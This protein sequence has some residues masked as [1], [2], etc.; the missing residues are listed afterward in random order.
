MSVPSHESFEDDYDRR[1]IVDFWDRYSEQFSRYTRGTLEDNEWVGRKLSYLL[2]EVKNLRIADLGTGA[3]FVAISFAQLGHS[4]IATDI[5]ERMIEEA[6]KNAE[7]YDVDIDFRL[8][9]IEHTKLEKGYFDLVILRDVIFNIRDIRRVSSEVVDLIRPGGYLVVADGNYFLHCHDEDYMHRHDYH[10]IRD[11]MGEYQKMTEMS[12]SQYKELEDLVKTFEVNTVCRP[13]GD[14]YLLT[15]LGLKNTTISCDDADDYKKLTEDGWTQV[16]FRYTLVAQK[17][18]DHD[19]FTSRTSYYVDDLFKEKKTTAQ[20]LS[21]IFEALSNPDRVRILNVLNNGPA[22]V[23]TIS[24]AVKLSEKMT[25]YHLTL[26]KDLGIVK[27]EKV[28]RESIYS[29]TDM[30]AVLN[31]FK[32][33]FEISSHH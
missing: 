21:K 9:D 19:Q 28:G 25:S 17:P 12:D 33:A 23:G 20:D 14:M 27:S 26:M 30:P 24:Q 11:R 13:Y 16:P 5:S 29:H 15:R 4:V 2:P 8:D 10:Y 32:V 3:G 6:R 31:L 1:D 18:Y 7:E 22:N